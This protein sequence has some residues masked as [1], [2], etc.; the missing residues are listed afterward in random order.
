[1]STQK[2]L[3]FNIENIWFTCLKDLFIVRLNIHQFICLG[4][5]SIMLELVV[6]LTLITNL[7]I[8][9]IGFDWILSFYNCR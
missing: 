5:K 2:A 4:F 3:E 6:V 9:F 1:M 7:F 8:L